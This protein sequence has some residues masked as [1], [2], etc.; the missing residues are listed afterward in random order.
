MIVPVD[1][2]CSHILSL[3]RL[4]APFSADLRICP[5]DQTLMVSTGDQRRGRRAAD[6]EWWKRGP[7]W[8]PA[9]RPLAL[10]RMVLP[11]QGSRRPWSAGRAPGAI[12]IPTLC[13][14]RMGSE[15]Q[16]QPCGRPAQRHG[17]EPGGAPGSHNRAPRSSEARLVASKQQG[18][19][20]RRLFL[21]LAALSTW[22]RRWLMARTPGVAT[23]ATSGV[24]ERWRGGQAQRGR[25]QQRSE[26]TLHAIPFPI[27]PKTLRP[28]ACQY[29][30][31]AAQ[32]GIYSL[33]LWSY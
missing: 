12:G 27:A 6:H 7:T 28:P 25:E 5:A 10:R 22:R 14:T 2:A 30:P 33:L 32:W 20:R 21:L 29:H 9:P 8:Q 13:L 23:S 19:N 3:S 4:N 16:G 31:V 17:G 18:P 1:P 11:P 26:L 24:G 15:G